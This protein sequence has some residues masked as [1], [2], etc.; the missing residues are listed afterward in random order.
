MA[1]SFRKLKI[2]Q[3]IFRVTA[4]HLHK[5]GGP[6]EIYY[7]LASCE[8]HAENLTRVAFNHLHGFVPYSFVEMSHD[9]AEVS[10][11]CA[12]M[13]TGVPL[14]AKVFYIGDLL[15]SKLGVLNPQQV[16]AF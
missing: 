12:R 14:G 8:S 1:T 16:L 4:T 5:A 3:K 2:P 6:T 10:E 9:T 13:Q 15:R 7:S 11:E